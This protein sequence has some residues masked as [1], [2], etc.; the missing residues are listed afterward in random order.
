MKLPL[1]SHHHSTQKG[2]MLLEALASIMIFSF[3]VLGILGMITT[4]IK[5]S[6]AAK[7]RTDAYLVAN[8]LLGKMWAS[9][10]TPATLKD[11]FQGG[12]GTNGAEYT[13]WL[14][15][16]KD[17][18]RLPGVK[19]DPDLAPKVTIITIDGINPPQ[20]AKSRVTIQIFWQQSGEEAP[21][22]Y[23]TVTEMK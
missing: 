3:G 2:Y 7:Y 15:D 23:L 18:N 6:T 5:T 22:N 11:K 17:K 20:T 10:K 13:N 14:N 4:S 12:S 9:D 1:H 8:D 21:H 19:E 16:I